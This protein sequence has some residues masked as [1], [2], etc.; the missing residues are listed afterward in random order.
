MWFLLLCLARDLLSWACRLVSFI[1]HYLFKYSNTPFASSFLTSPPETLIQ[2]SQ[3]CHSVMSNSLWPHE[4]QHARL[5]CPS[6]TAGVHPN[7]CPLSRWCHPIISSSFIPF[8]SHLQ[9]FP[10]SVSFQLS[11]FFGS[12]GQSIGVSA[13]ASVLPMNTQD[14]SPLGWTG[15][16]CSPRDT[17]QSFPTV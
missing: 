11:Q 9:S 12:G 6:P 15:W 5:P 16:T 2:F 4:L 8:S 13:S 14:W 10:A 3:F 7:S 1:S 17:Q